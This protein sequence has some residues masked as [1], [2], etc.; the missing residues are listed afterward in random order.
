VPLAISNAETATD[1]QLIQI[2]IHDQN[3]ILRPFV[4]PP[5]TPNDRVAILR[6]AF[7]NTLNDPDFKTDAAKA[8]LDI[9][10]VSGEEI[11][12]TV[13]GLFKLDP[14]LVNKL[15]EVLYN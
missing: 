15:K 13:H 7:M 12:K 2:G 6:Q 1:R 11:D 14:P 10:P 4:L 9:E 5:K 3:T 8:Q